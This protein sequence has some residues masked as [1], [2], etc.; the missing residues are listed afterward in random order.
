MNKAPAKFKQADV[1][2]AVAGV[3]SCGLSIGRVEIGVDGK[4][5]VYTADDLNAEKRS[6]YDA[7]KA[8]QNARSS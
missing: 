4:I 2:R 7:W 8:G 3:K 6:A 1:K 5:A